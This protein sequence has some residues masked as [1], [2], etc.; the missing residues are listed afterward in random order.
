M[1][2]EPE[3][4]ALVIHNAENGD[5]LWE[6]D[7]GVFNVT[8]IRRIAEEN[9][10]LC[11]PFLVDLEREF[12]SYVLRSCG[13]DLDR[14]LAIPLRTAQREAFLAVEDEDGTTRMI[15]GHHRLVR[16]N[17]A[18]M[19]NFLAWIVPNDLLPPMVTFSSMPVA[20]VPPK[21]AAM[22]VRPEDL[23]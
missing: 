10:D 23:R 14:A 4:M 1:S 22:A 21:L 7:D 20:K 8:R 16:L 12:V 17:A 3:E 5:V 13:V 9:P 18:G 19:K 6:A 15:D 11:G 2:D